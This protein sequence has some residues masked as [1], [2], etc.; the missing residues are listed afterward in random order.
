MAEMNTEAFV[1]VYVCLWTDFVS[2]TALKLSTMQ[3][4]RCGAE[5]IMKAK[6]WKQC[7]V[8]RKAKPKQDYSSPCSFSVMECANEDLFGYKK[9]FHPVVV[10]NHLKNQ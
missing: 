5:V 3:F 4:C 10:D 6:F 1:L 2:V 9:H 7:Y 8:L